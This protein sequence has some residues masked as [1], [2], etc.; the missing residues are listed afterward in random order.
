MAGAGGDGG[1][2]GCTTNDDCDAA[3][4]CN[5]EACSAPGT[6]EAR[7]IN[8]TDIFLPVCGCDGV[9][10][11]NGCEA[12]AAGVSIES[13]GECACE[14]NDDCVGTDYCAADTCD[15]PGECVARPVTCPLVFDP[16]CGCDDQT[17]SNSCEAAAAGVRVQS[18]GACL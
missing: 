1:S 11:G 4:F 6:C 7:P 2:A 17:Y 14:S 10:Y 12:E 13:E 15:D 9:T 16:V 3:D 5:L 8:C 18:D